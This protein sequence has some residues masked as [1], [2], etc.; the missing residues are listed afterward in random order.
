LSSFARLTS[1]K[2]ESAWRGIGMGMK[3]SNKQHQIQTD[4]ILCKQTAYIA[5]V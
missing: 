2:S 4:I 5:A 3:G 1:K